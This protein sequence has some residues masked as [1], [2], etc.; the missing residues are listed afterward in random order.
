MNLK[1]NKKSEI[2][3]LIFRR[4]IFAITKSKNELF[5]KKNIK[6]FRPKLGQ[7]LRTISN[8]RKK[9]KKNIKPFSPI[10]KTY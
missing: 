3:S 6:C 9:A 8:N 5:T 4:S 1:K 7:E 2:P 10:F